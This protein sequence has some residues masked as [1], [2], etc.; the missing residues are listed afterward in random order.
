MRRYNIAILKLLI[1]CGLLYLLITLA[2]R[3]A[4][5]FIILAAGL[6]IFAAFD[7]IKGVLSKNKVNGFM[8][9]FGRKK[10]SERKRQ[11]ATNICPECGSGMVVRA[12]KTGRYKGKKFMGCRRFPA[13][14]GII[15]RPD[16]N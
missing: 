15:D 16:L 4:P 2:G 9:P 11:K 3:V 8:R 13:C 14:R 6:M 12:A 5:L 7:M 10:F 1:V